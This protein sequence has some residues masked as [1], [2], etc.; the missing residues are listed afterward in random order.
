MTAILMY[1][2]V[3]VKRYYMNMCE[4]SCAHIV[5]MHGKSFIS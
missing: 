4:S 1:I 5:L 2:G 3:L